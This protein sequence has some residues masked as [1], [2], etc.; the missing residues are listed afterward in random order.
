MLEVC[1]NKNE[2]IEV[3]KNTIDVNKFNIDRKEE[4]KGIICKKIGAK[5]NQLII[6]YCGR[7]VED[8]GVLELIKA[9]KQLDDERLRLMII[10]SSVYAGGKKTE[11]VR[12]L[13]HEAKGI[14][15]GYCFTGY[16]PQK[17]LPEYIKASDIAVVPSIWQE[18]AGNVIIEALACGIPVVA[19]TQG[20]I[21]EYADESACELV[22]YNECFISNIA[23]ALYKLINNNE[24]YKFKCANSRQVALKYSKYNYYTNFIDVVK[25]LC[26][27]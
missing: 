8:K 2:R 4:V 1:P 12:K 5:E 20:G 3:L 18:A 25:K 11:Y 21:P 27:K 19:S 15:G 17:E 6:S 22:P 10:G 13:E 14:L 26:K 23:S 9:I 24:L 16:I 7:L